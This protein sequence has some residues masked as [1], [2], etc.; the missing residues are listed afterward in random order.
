MSIGSASITKYVRLCLFALFVLAQT[1]PPGMAFA[2]G[3]DGFQIV[4]CTADGEKSVSWEELTGE[5]SPFEEPHQDD[6]GGGPCHACVKS[7]R[8][9]MGEG[10]QT[11]VEALFSQKPR[12]AIPATLERT[13]AYYL[14]GPPLPSRSPPA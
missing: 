8:G 11:S 12:T 9:G 14:T 13:T 3:D 6:A 10:P 5:P 1:V 7:C 2:A 4:I